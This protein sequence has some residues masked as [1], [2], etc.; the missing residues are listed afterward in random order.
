M[1][2]ARVPVNVIHLQ[3]SWLIP[4]FGDATTGTYLFQNSG[5]D[6]SLFDVPVVAEILNGFSIVPVRTRFP[7][8]PLSGQEVRGFQS[9]GFHPLLDALDG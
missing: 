7:I 8:A 2:V 6:E 1:V 3:G 4:P 5:F 9:H